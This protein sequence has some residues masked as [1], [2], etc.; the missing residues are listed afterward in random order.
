MQRKQHQGPQPQITAAPVDSIRAGPGL[1]IRPDERRIGK[2]EKLI[3]K[4]GN[5]VPV[6]ATYSETGELDIAG[7][8]D[9]FSAYQNSG[10]VNIPI[11]IAE[12]E[13]GADA[14]LLALEMMAAHPVG[15]LAVS[16]CLCKL[17]DE[18]MVS[19][20]AIA[21]ALGKSLPWVSMAERVGRHLV[22]DV[23]EMLACGKLCMRS[24]MEIALLPAETQK[25]FADKAATQA[26]NKDQVSKWVSLYL[27]KDRSRKDKNAMM[28]DPIAYLKAAQRKKA[29]QSGYVLF[30]RALRNCKTTVQEL[31]RIIATLPHSAMDDVSTQLQELLSDVTK[32]NDQTQDIFTRVNLEVGA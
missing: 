21:E 24:A 29:A 9:A 13:G 19:R 1:G 10:A 5:I 15:Q 8:H 12:T 14:L 17:I 3:E 16:S 6:T 23:K 26:L 25:P 30:R 27:A 22:S 7:G 2:Y 32:L 20:S 28:D 18:Y 4:R 11:I 31:S